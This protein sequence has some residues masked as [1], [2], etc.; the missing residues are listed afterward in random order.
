MAPTAFSLVRVGHRVDATASR[1]YE[2]VELSS[3][4]GV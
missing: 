4:V 3:P 1:T 2:G